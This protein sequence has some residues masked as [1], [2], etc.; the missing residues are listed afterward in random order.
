MK[1]GSLGM[2]GKFGAS[3][4]KSQEVKRGEKGGHSSP[5]PRF[6]I[7]W[8]SKAKKLSKTARVKD[9]VCILGWLSYFPFRLFTI[10]R[11]N[12]KERVGIIG[13]LFNCSSHA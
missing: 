7:P 1:D 11:V 13:V 8:T 9:S 10:L 5:D 6:R 2:K 3:G 12:E 4:Q